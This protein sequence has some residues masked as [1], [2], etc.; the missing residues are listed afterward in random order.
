MLE[1]LGHDDVSAAT[2]APYF[3][4]GKDNIN[5]S[6]FLDG[7]ATPMRDLSEPEELAAA[8][9][10]FDVDDSGQIDLAELRSAVLDAARAD[11]EAMSGSMVDGILDEFRA[12]RAFGSRGV[13]GKELGAGTRGDVFRYR[14][15][16][17][18]I[19]G[20]GTATA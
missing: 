14:D 9:A 2:L 7:L 19:T 20:A 6:R 17:S 11:G 3:S 8:F 1:Q 18:A 5:L 16:M 13:L 10:A 4:N 12:R 15:F